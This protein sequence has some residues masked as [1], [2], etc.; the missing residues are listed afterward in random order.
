MSQENVE[1][2]QR[3]AERINER[4]IDGMLR[5]DPRERTGCG[6]VSRSRGV[7]EVRRFV[8]WCLR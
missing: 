8:A 2:V 6:R 4:D 7:R 3:L 1:V 5:L